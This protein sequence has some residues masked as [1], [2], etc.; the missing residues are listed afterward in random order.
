MF[1]RL[2]HWPLAVG[3]LSL[4]WWPCAHALNPDLR[5]DQLNHTSWTQKDGVPSDITSMAQTP[6]GWLWLGTRGGLYR[7]DGM[8]FERYPLKGSRV[9]KLHAA[10]NGDLL[11]SFVPDGLMVLHADGSSTQLPPLPHQLGTFRAMTLDRDGAIWAINLNGLYRYAQGRWQVMSSGAEWAEATQSL[12]VDQYGRLWISNRQALYRHDRATDK[13]VR[14]EGEGMQGGLLLSPDGRLWINGNDD[15][16]RL[17]PMPPLGQHAQRL[18]SFN[19]GAARSAGQ[20]DRDGNLWVPLCPRGIC[21]MARAGARRSGALDPEHEA[22]DRLDQPWQLSDLGTRGVLEDREGNVW[23]FTKSGIDRFREN[24]LIPANMAG[25]AG[26]LNAASDNAGKLWVADGQMNSIWTIG[27]DGVAVRDPQRSGTSIATDRDG[28]IL[29]AGRR[30]IERIYRGQSSRIAFPER[31]GKPADI[32]VVS[33]FDDGKVLWVVSMQAGL[34]AWMD[35]RWHDRTEFNIPQRIYMLAPGGPG[36]MWLS[37]NDGSLKFLDNGKLTPYDIALVGQESGIFPGPQLVV[38][39][40]RGIAVLL[41]HKFVALGPAGVEA[42]RNV[43][44]MAVTADGDRWLNGGRGLVHIRRED[45]DAS[46]RQP[47]IPLVY[48]LIDS[49]EG[50]P[51]QA[52]LDNRQPS[53]YDMGG[54]VLWLRGSGGLVRLDT[55]KLRPNPVRPVAQLLRVNVDNRS[56]PATSPLRLPPDTRS[57]NIQYTAPSLRKPEAMRFQYR[58]DGVDPQWQD[59]GSRRAAYYTNVGP[60]RYTFSVRAVNEDGLAGTSVATL[61]LEIA[62]TVVQTWWFQLMCVLAAI[63]AV[64]GLYRYRL[65]K[66]TAAIA[67]QLEVRMDERVRI[68]RTLHDTF[69]QSVQA[70]I[71]RVYTV[72]TK[73]PEDSEPRIKLESILTQAEQAINEGR[74]QVQQLRSGRDLQE[75]IEGCGNAMAAQHEGVAFNLVSTGTPRRLAPPVQEELCAIAQ[76]ALTNAFRHGHASQITA[77]L[78][79][80]R[81][82]LSLSVVDDGCGIDDAQLRRRMHG[83]HF[84]MVGMHE[85]A[86]RVGTVL[87]VTSAPGK[88]TVLA[89]KVP[90][91]LCYVSSA[92]A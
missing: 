92:G 30:Y 88:G 22:T 73:L 86:K 71:L 29:V 81:D 31:D 39:G 68:A 75:Q 54:G 34:M 33:M 1:M 35:G 51:G 48:E 10:D 87:E 52:T 74:D 46:V 61:Q 21:R 82:G 3:L 44:G 57:F 18:P 53:V 5:L 27:A 13:L 85:R 7:F 32:S 66:A 69:L 42:L 84:G 79:Y 72:L 16:V 17:V 70:L 50:Y 2:Y 89:L 59:A 14:V 83:G 15:R 67:R 24:K 58:L 36:Q 12:V 76:E 78:D 60:G 91:E 20:F 45:W 19:Q 55:A 11:I 43:S 6:D 90:A 8:T 28:A 65:S 77:R 64:Y 26:E 49:Q 4:L 9:Y 37:N 80:L 47:A 25:V 63:L 41:D 23:I 56:Y 38:A 62:P 40:E